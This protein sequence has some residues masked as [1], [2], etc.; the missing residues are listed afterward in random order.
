M[1]TV[2]ILFFEGCPSVELASSRAR[3]AIEQAGTPAEVHMVRV[4]SEAE[5][6]ARRFPGSP[7][8]RVE[9]RDVETSADARTD[10][11]MQCRVYPVEGRL[12]AAP[13]TAWIESA[14][15]GAFIGSTEAQVTAACCA[16][17]P[18]RRKE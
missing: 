16:S 14:L 18:P 8:V 2:E 11:G 6:V 10:F 3:Q 1:K 15:R 9:G 17:P 13:P 12:E 4:E 5:A 7:T